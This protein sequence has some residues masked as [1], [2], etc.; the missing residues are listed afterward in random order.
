MLRF[1]QFIIEAGIRRGL[2]H[3]ST[4]HHDDFHNLIHTGKID[5]HH[6]TEKTDGFTHEFGHD[7]HGFYSQSSASGNERMRSSK[8]F[9]DRVKR[10]E[11]ESGKP[12]NY[13]AAK[14]FGEIHDHLAN[15]Q[16][17]Q[18]H[19]RDQYKKHGHAR[20]KGEVFHKP[21]GKPGNKKGEIKFVGTSYRTDHMASVG[22]Y[23]I[24]SKL[25]ENQHND[26]H[27][28]IHHLSDHAYNFDTDHVDHN[29]HPN[30]TRIDVSTEKTEHDKLNHDLIRTRKTKTNKE[31][32]EAE[33][34]KLSKIQR[35]V[36]DK[37]DK[38]MKKLGTAPKWGS[39]TEGMV[40]H[41]PE[42]SKQP[43]FKV[44]SDAFRKFKKETKK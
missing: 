14:A 44:T 12:G 6:Q 25:P 24:H 18:A 15:N 32:K 19:L 13:N 22:K 28:F 21:D 9:H 30:S 39:G 31:E 17:L 26:V 1:K 33:H 42:K 38:H 43:R 23:V 36:S 2:P 27:H 16:K 8:D 35:T 41:P 3:V 5:L 20:V 11:K 10:R 34:E 29:H 4:M 37:I 7:E 40:I